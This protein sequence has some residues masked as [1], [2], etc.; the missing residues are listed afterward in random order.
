MR[1]KQIFKE[2]AEFMVKHDSGITRFRYQENDDK[3]EFIDQDGNVMSQLYEADRSKEW[4]VV[5][6]MFMG[7]IV[8][9]T[10]PYYRIC[11]PSSAHLI[12]TSKYIDT[13]YDKK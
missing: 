4:F 11:R 9:K 5:A 3:G 13:N 1:H 6:G 12:K 8:L 2:K 7:E 10:I